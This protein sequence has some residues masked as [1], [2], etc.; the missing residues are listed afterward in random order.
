MFLVSIN[1]EWQCVKSLDGYE[2]CLFKKLDRE[3]FG[4]LGET[5]DFETGKIIFNLEAVMPTL[6]DEIKTHAAKLIEQISPDWKQTNDI[7]SPSPLGKA[8]FEAIDIIRAWSNDIESRLASIDTVEAVLSI[9]AEVEA[10]QYT[11]KP[12]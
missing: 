4:D 1:D 6:I 8:R 3:P 2:G 9:R 7:R 5:I 10:Y 12:S 11:G